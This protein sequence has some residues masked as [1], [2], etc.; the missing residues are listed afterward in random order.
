M[1]KGLFMTNRRP[2]EPGTSGADEQIVAFRRR[3]LANGYRFEHV[4]GYF[5]QSE[6]D[7][8][9]TL[10][11]DSVADG[12][13]EIVEVAIESCPVGATALRSVGRDQAASR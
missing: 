6:E 12:D 9:V 10:L 2:G 1:R 7:G 11:R 5:R 8:R 3:C 13:R 4:P